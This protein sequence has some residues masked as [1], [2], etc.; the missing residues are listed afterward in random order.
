[1]QIKTLQKRNAL[2]NIYQVIEQ[3]CSKL[4]LNDTPKNSLALRIVNL[5]PP[6]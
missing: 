2:T 1:M 4:I 5:D 6:T 3:F